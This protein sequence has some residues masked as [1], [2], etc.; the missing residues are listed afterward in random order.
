MRDFKK[1][2]IWRDMENVEKLFKEHKM[3]AKFIEDG[4]GYE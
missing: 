3:L 1:L 2:L 4:S